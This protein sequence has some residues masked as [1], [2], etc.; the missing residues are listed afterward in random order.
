MPEEKLKMC[1]GLLQ[2]D[3]GEAVRVT[4]KPIK[5]CMPSDCSRNAIPMQNVFPGGWDEEVPTV[6]HTEANQ[7]GAPGHANMGDISAR[8]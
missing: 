3:N 4:N 6:F 7:R 1:L 8:V 2:E 5:F